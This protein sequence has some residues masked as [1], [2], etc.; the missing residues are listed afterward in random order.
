MRDKTR[1][2]AAEQ[3]TSITGVFKPHRE[4]SKP[5]IVLIEGDPGIGKTTYCQKLAYDWA[6][7]QET[8]A[9]FPKIKLLLLLKCHGMSGNI[10]E[11]IDDQLLPKDIEEEAK[12]KFFNYIR[13][14][15]SQVLL[16]LDGLD[17]A[18][19]NLTRMFADLVESRELP[20]CNIVLTSRHEGGIKLSKYCDTLLE[21]VGFAA[22]SSRSFIVRYF[23]D[24]E[25]LAQELLEEI[26]QKQELKEL[27]ANPLFTA[28]L[29]LVCEDL[30]GS[31]P[32]SKTQLYLEITNCVLKRFHRK[33][34]FSDN[35]ENLI[36]VYKKELE[37]LGQ[38]A[39]KGLE[40]DEMY[41]E[42]SRLEGTTSESP[43]FE[44]L[45]VQSESSKRRSRTYYRFSHKSFQEFFGGFYLSRQISEG[46]TDFERV[47][48]RNYF[49][50]TQVLLYTVGIIGLRCEK[51][52]LSLLNTI[53]KKA[54]IS[55]N[56]FLQNYYLWFSLE[57]IGECTTENSRLRTRI[58]ELLGT[59][60][61][62][63]TL[64]ILGRG[65]EIKL[66]AE[67][68]KYNTTVTTL[69]L[70]V[71]L[72]GDVCAVSLAETL[73]VNNT[74]RVIGMMGNLIS[75]Y[76]VQQLVD[77]LT[78]NSTLRALHLS[79]NVLEDNGA[80]ILAEYLKDNKALTALH[81]QDNNI[82]NEG[83]RSLAESLRINTILNVLNLSK[84]PSIGNPGAMS[85]C[86]ALK[87]NKTL[88]SLGLSDSGIGDTGI[89]SLSEVLKT[90]TSL[91]SLD[92]SDV[93]ISARGVR[94]VAEVLRE[95]STLN[96]LDFQG[97]KVGVGGARLISESLKANAS[98]KH[99][100]L[101]RNNIKA[102]CARLF[103]EALQVN[104]T[105]T[106]LSLAENDLGARGAQ[107]L[108]DALRV[109]TS[110]THLDLSGN[111][112][113]AAAAESIVETLRVNATLTSL[114]LSENSIGDHGA[115]SLSEALKVN[116]SLNNLNLSVNS[117]GAAGAESIAEALK[118]NTT[119]TLLDL[120]V[121]FI[122]DCGAQSLAEA[123]K[124]NATLTELLL[125]NNLIQS[126]GARA[127]AE[128]RK[129]NNTLK[130]LNLMMNN[131]GNLDDVGD[132]ELSELPLLWFPCSSFV[133]E[134]A[135]RF[136]E[137]SYD[138]FVSKETIVRPQ[139]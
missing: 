64:E 69:F 15:Q 19:S 88:S 82:G 91:T 96:H 70:S 48:A 98:L 83:A 12:E 125:G 131:V 74:L 97:N 36:E 92:L 18:P 29:C 102:K 87:V 128:L 5:R 85:L 65:C 114:N 120:S 72:S 93:K 9:S 41:V 13:A 14:N 75:A 139:Q 59:N 46:E 73:R 81:I 58:T 42:E 126:L 115:K 47:L 121:N 95:N 122:G 8:D 32:T 113:G 11:A 67:A 40:R 22:E 132:E 56:E 89:Q 6:N 124:T 16:V 7:G 112:I 134:L 106:S 49:K 53:I 30:K 80:M 51:D 63:Q 44:F 99:L 79:V 130:M 20:N 86:E 57:C 1:R 116:V 123:L 25:A 118:R 23:E 129:H 84:N 33:Q 17:E 2:A 100:D 90:N 133:G 101:S 78:V 62:L 52:A 71:Q 38:I 136:T 27:T 111:A 24:M 45:A 28:L 60:L 50:F 37:Q 138:M 108:S 31:P 66:L 43:L 4:C 107:L 3:I 55:S 21:I 10:W 76:G 127:F 105:L 117:I 104:G 39:L 109:N 34:G 26:E 135:L 94:S 110:L 77:A 54:N 61:E 103:S 68:L 35:T 119:L 137:E